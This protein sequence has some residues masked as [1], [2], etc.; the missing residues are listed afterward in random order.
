MWWTDGRMNRH[1]STAP[2]ALCITSRGKKITRKRRKILVCGGSSVRLM[3]LMDFS[4]CECNW[5]C[6]LIGCNTSKLNRKLSAT[7][8]S[9][10]RTCHHGSMP[11]A[12]SFTQMSKMGFSR[13]VAPLNVT[14]IG[15]KIWYYSF[16]TVNIWKIAHKYNRLRDFYEILSIVGVY[17][18]VEHLSHICIYH[19][20]GYFLAIFQ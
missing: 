18:Q 14:F 5:S 2:S 13:H 19:Q 20:R 10:T 11:L 1:L 15:V 8:H 3:T 17:I 6:F 4:K 16:K 12:I 9:I 7:D